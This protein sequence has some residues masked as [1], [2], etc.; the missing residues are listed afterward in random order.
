MSLLVCLGALLF[1]A[2]VFLFLP[3]GGEGATITVDDD[4]GADYTKIQD[5]IDNATDGDTIEVWEGTYDESVNI[6][7]QLRVSGAGVDETQLVGHNTKD[8]MVITANRTAVE[9][10]TFKAGLFHV[11]IKLEANRTTLTNNRFINNS[12]GIFTTKV[13]MNNSIIGNSF[14]GNLEGIFLP[15]STGN[16]IASNHFTGNDRGLMIDSH[17]DANTVIGNWFN[18]T[19]GIGIFISDSDEC[20]IIDNTI[21]NGGVGVNIHSS[22]GILLRNNTSTDHYDFGYHVRFCDDITFTNCQASKNE[23]GYNIEDSQNI[24]VI[25]GTI[26][27]ND[28]GIHSRDIGNLYV[29]NNSI[30]WNEVGVQ[31][32]KVGSDSKYRFNDISNNSAFGIKGY[33]M[34]MNFLDARFNWWG[35]TT[36]PFH[37]ESNRNG[38]ANNVSNSVD[39][40][41]WGRTFQKKIQNLD[42]DTKYLT[43]EEAVKDANSYDT[44]YVPSGMYYEHILIDKPL[45]ILGAESD[46]VIVDGTNRDIIIEIT[47]DNV[48]IRKV[49]IQ[50]SG[51]SSAGI[52]IFSK[53]SVIAN[54]IISNCK[55]G[56]LLKETDHCSILNNSISNIDVYGI[57]GSSSCT[58]DYFNNNSFVNCN[59]Y[60]IYYGGSNTRFENNSLE[61]TSG[62]CFSGD[63]N[64]I[65]GNQAY[66]GGVYGIIISGDNNEIF[67][68]EVYGNQNGLRFAGADNNVAH[69][70]IVHDN[71]YGVY[72]YDGSSDCELH[73]NSIA[74]SE[75]KG[76]HANNREMTNNAS[77]NWWGDSSGP[78]HESKNPN[79]VGDEVSD[80]II[81]EPWLQDIPFPDYFEPSLAI[82]DI[83]PV[84]AKTEDMVIIECNVITY[85]GYSRFHCNSSIDGT[86]Y[87]GNTNPIAVK[88]LTSGI[89][90][91]TIKILDVFGIWS[92]EV[93]ISL[94]AIGKPTCSIDSIIPEPDSNILIFGEEISF[95]A[96]ASCVNDSIAVYL[97]TSNIDGEIHNGTEYEF[98][99]SSLSSGAQNISLKVMDDFGTW[100]DAVHVNFE[101]HPLPEAWISSPNNGQVYQESH[102]IVFATEG[103]NFT[104]ISLYV[105]LSD[106]DG[107]LFSGPDPTFTS[108][109]LSTGTHTISLRV[110]D[111]SGIWSEE[112]Y[113]TLI[114]HEKPNASINSITPTTAL[115]GNDV[116]F[117]GG[118]FDDGSIKR[119]AW[120]SSIDG[121]FSNTTFSLTTTFDLS[122]GNHTISLRV[123]DDHGA[124]SDH[125]TG[126]LVIE[127]PNLFPRITV[128]EN[129]NHEIVSGTITFSGTA[130][131]EDGEIETV[132][133]SISPRPNNLVVSGTDTWSY[134]LDTTTLE[135]GE[136]HITFKSFDGEAYSGTRQITITVQNDD[137]G[138]GGG[139]DDGVIPGFGSISFIISLSFACIIQAIIHK[140]RF[141]S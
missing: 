56:I 57:S 43:I 128:L 94:L 8:L 101:I 33:S 27:G 99:T 134:K 114:I 15:Q 74:N 106:L 85:S 67:E 137:P 60:G 104:I 63:F 73:N 25:N 130:W 11:G 90:T 111:S 24:R 44:I 124:W 79:G 1:L 129:H 64:R 76:I 120:T 50:N 70:N 31:I 103:T 77:H 87:E 108:S 72:F 97:W 20:L 118:G 40:R 5:A 32:S 42:L 65:R 98:S 66:N 26:L 132:F 71:M 12:Q 107:E 135:N 17:G 21:T 19:L 54:T 125:V 92:T 30:S 46:S 78:Y 10:I 131:D 81:F 102:E 95:Q 34:G 4:G 59:G 16:V 127:A 18:D 139:G 36:G 112:V 48:T 55:Y 68:N 3:D 47:A 7:K 38:T 136:Y 96:K 62:C 45:M 80:W 84:P 140:R 2:L 119:Y 138:K 58:F 14:E 13:C 82:K 83:N 35:N 100:S 51:S 61:N 116:A 122:I 23:I 22:D 141:V 105:W 9:N 115:Y 29:E 89:H 49:T 52:Q 41:P 69:H 6:D 37:E 126:V 86:L 91:I 75:Y 121:E 39:F 113:G 110:Q 53:N 123:Q 117:I 133:V 28:A 93:N 109:I 88:G